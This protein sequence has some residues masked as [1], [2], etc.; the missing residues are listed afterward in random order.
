MR[1]R[2]LVL[3]AG[4]LLASGAWAQHVIS[5]RA[6]YL[7]YQHGQV[8][9]PGGVDGKNLRQIGEGQ[10]VATG[11]GR[12]ELLLTPG[13]YLRLDNE[14]EARMLSTRLQDVKVELLRGTASLE[15]IE[16]AKDN[17]LQ[18]IWRGHAIPITKPGLYRFEPNPDSMRVYVLSG[19]LRL[20][21]SQ[22]DIK[23][24]RYEDISASGEL[25][26][27][28]KFNRK[29]LDEFD[30]FNAR[31]GLALSAASYRAASVFGRPRGFRSSLWYADPW[32]GFYTFLPYSPFV[33]SPFWGF[34]YYGP[35]YV[36]TPGY[37][38][39]HHGGSS[40][41]STG[42]S[43][44]SAP[45]PPPKAAPAPAPAPPPRVAPP[46]MGGDRGGQHGSIGRP[47]VPN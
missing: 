36:S 8:I 47:K 42:G 32:S 31:R 35:R 28:A 4:T 43:T 39:G 37:Y 21:G 40:G 13:S 3:L 19:K 5:V 46:S 23:A 2:M 41:G 14:S 30:R 25:T 6:G 29:D 9:L 20:P 33:T 15:V 44:G 18:V 27:V 38:G 12:V 22:K 11:N 16:I 45:P 7:N 34:G 10:Q 17:S 24:G 1:S 26:A